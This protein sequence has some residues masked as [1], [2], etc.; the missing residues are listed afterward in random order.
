MFVIVI[1]FRQNRERRRE[2]ERKA[3]ESFRTSV[4]AKAFTRCKIDYFIGTAVWDDFLGHK[5][6][7]VT[8]AI[9]QLGF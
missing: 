7:S 6:F 5:V 4:D 8:S 3:A 1:L 2:Q 9:L